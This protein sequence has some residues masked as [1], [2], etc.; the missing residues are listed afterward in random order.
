MRL[1]T[2]PGIT[3]M[4]QVNGRSNVL[5]FEEVVRLDASYM[6]NYAKFIIWAAIAWFSNE[7]I[8]QE[9][10]VKKKQGL[11]ME[12]FEKRKARFLYSPFGRV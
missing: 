10:L 4:W 8:Y 7:A 12:A 5:D 2:K 1:A 6:P 3:G 11:S 9:L